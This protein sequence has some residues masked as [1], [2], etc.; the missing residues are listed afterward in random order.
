MQITHIICSSKPQ[1]F[2]ITEDLDTE[3]LQSDP[4]EISQADRAKLKKTGKTSW[5][6]SVQENIKPI[7]TNLK[8]KTTIFQHAR[9]IGMTNEKKENINPMFYTSEIKKLEPIIKEKE[10]EKVEYLT[11]RNNGNRNINTNTYN[12]SNTSRS[13]YNNNTGNNYI[14][15]NRNYSS[16]TNPNYNYNNE[17]NR[18]SRTNNNISRTNQVYSRGNYSN[19]GK[20]GEIV[21]ET[22]TKVQMGSRSQYRNVGNPVSSVITE[23]K[24]YTS[25]NFFNNK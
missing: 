19:T 8:G 22:R 1:D 7:K 13:N 24:V 25:N 16:N 4:I 10:K 6:T 3:Y 14:Q 2:H 5:T 23:K 17:N 9:G 15:Q 11:F 12:T 18:S 21:K 20:D